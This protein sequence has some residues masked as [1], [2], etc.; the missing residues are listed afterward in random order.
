MCALSAV[1]FFASAWT[2]GYS[3]DQEHKTLQG[4]HHEKK[5]LDPEN[6]DSE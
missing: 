1:A 4:Y 6:G 2:K 3:L 5:E